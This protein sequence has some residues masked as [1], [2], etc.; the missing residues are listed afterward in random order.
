VTPCKQNNTHM[1]NIKNPKNILGVTLVELMVAITISSIVAIGIGSVYTSSKRSFKL[2]EE[3]SRLQENGRFAMNYVARF[4]RGAGYSGCSSAL[5]NMYN[6]INDDDPDLNF[7]TGLEGYEALGT[8]PNETGATLAE[9][10]SVSATTSDFNILTSSGTTPITNALLTKL[11]VLPRSDILISRAAADS[12][13]EIVENNKSANFVINWISTEDKTTAQACVITDPTDPTKTTKVTGY[14]GICP[15]QFLLISDC[16]KSVAF[17]VSNM[18]KLG[19]S[20]STVRIVHNKSGTPGNKS[21]SW[22][23]AGANADPGFD[24]VTGDELVTV[25][26]KYFYVGAGTNGPALFMKHGSATPLELVEGV[27]NMQVLYGEDIDGNSIPDRY[28]PAD[29]VTNFANVSV[30]RLSLLLR[31]VKN[32]S[33]RTQQS[34]NYFLGGMTNATST[35]ITSP[36]DQRL[37]RVMTMSI[38]VRNA[39]FS[40]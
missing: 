38:K 23:A 2:Q 25:A 12:G 11:G 8:A 9:Y 37:R 20:P 19:G 24:F 39:A 27:E 5:G 30:V 35:R 32:L 33:W 10:P 21:A 1:A 34:Q 15:D 16:E 4:V 26:T 22:G 6:D 31:S 17:Q 3:F 13:V 7:Q 40:L 36:S 18:S 29:Q 28:I 14:N